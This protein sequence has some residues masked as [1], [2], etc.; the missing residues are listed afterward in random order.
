MKRWWRWCEKRSVANIKNV[1][2]ITAA[3]TKTKFVLLSLDD[4]YSAADEREVMANNR[5]TVDAPSA[6]SK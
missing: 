2:Y 3:A 6:A 5:K 4:D 1:P